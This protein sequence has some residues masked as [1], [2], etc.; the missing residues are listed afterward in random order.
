MNSDTRTFRTGIDNYCLHPLGLSPI[1]LLAWAKEHGAEG[2]AFSGLTH[3]EYAQLTPGGLQDIAAFAGGNGMYL[4]WGGGRHIPRDMTTWQKTDV[5]A[6]NLARVREAAA[7][8]ARIIR[9]CSGGLMRWHP[10]SPPTRQ[11]MEETARALAEQRTMLEDHGVIL[12]LETHFEFTSFELLAV[13][14]MAGL[15]PGGPVGVCLDTMNLLVMLEDPL[16]AAKRLL[17][18][19]VSTHIKDGG[20]LLDE[21]G[22]HP[23][24]VPL[25][26][27]VVDLK[28]IM[29]LLRSQPRP[30]DL[31]VE[32]HGGVFDLPVDRQEFIAEF[33]DLTA[34][35]YGRLMQL[36]VETGEKMAQKTIAVT[37]REAWP[38]VCESRSANDIAALKT[39]RAAL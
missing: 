9:S 22:L 20:L 34:A 5:A 18:W 8:G 10:D 33:P 19:I 11:L 32:D 23:F 25:G 16:E 29:E 13:F 39:M 15:Q 2:V 30:I 6:D 21:T 31:S 17:P 36:A 7:L 1:H 27:G 4:E 28:G 37:P 38:E 14:E 3:K 26:K 12:A 24:P 35:A